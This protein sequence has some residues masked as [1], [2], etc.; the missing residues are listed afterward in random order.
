MLPSRLVA[1]LAFL[2]LFR[3]AASAEP[4]RLEDFS[5]NA[6]RT[7]LSAEANREGVRWVTGEALSNASAPDQ[8]LRL[9]PSFSLFRRSSSVGANPTAQGVSL[10]GIGPSG[11]SRTLVLLDGV[12]LNDPFGG[13]I[14]WT[15]L[16]TLALAGAE[17][18]HGGGSAAWGNAALSGT[19]ALTSSPLSSPRRELR[20]DAGSQDTR[21]ATL[22][23]GQRFGRTA[24]RVDA[25]HFTTEG[26]HPL[27]PADRGLIDRPLSSE[28]LLVQA[29]LEHE[30]DAVSAR[31]ALRHFA[32]ER[33]NGTVLQKN[34]SRLDSASLTLRGRL[35]ADVWQTALYRQRQTF[36]SFF[37]GIGAGR[38][39]E[40]PANDQFDV[41]S[42]AAGAGLT[43]AGER[44][45]TRFTTGLDY[46]QVRGETREDFLFAN[47]NFTRRRFAGGGQDFRGAFFSV[48]RDL[49]KNLEALL[50]VRADRWADRDGHR[51][52][53]DRN[54]GAATRTERYASRRGDE[55]HGTLALTWRPSGAWT[56]RGSAYTAFRLPTLNELYRPFRV[57]NVNTEANPAL[58]AESLR[59]VEA[60][61]AHQTERA[62]FAL[63][64]FVNELHDAVANVTLATSPTLVSRQRLNLSRL[65]VRGLE[66]QM[67]ITAFRDLDFEASFFRVDSRVAAA[68]VQPALV[69]R[70]VAQVPNLTLTT[71]AEWR[72]TRALRVSA[73]ARWS[74]AQFEDDENTLS[75]AS[76]GTLDVAAEH[77]LNPTLV[78]SLAVE[79]VLDR[80]VAAARSAGGP[81]SYASPRV[82]RA[83]VR[84]AF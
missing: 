30:F 35:G 12:P 48:E 1:C 31:L 13:W 41:P 34:S 47:G 84:L 25:R 63:T 43:Y 66:G 42:D 72:A 83:S 78:V 4:V 45:A 16:P 2:T 67:R 75:L 32:E 3:S 40:T 20:L 37:S 50:Q 53:I 17:I 70:R 7:G 74:S 11:A 51:R 9:D 73:Q 81:T 19:I 68:A 79:N 23:L 65:R 80:A 69:G 6:A 22:A 33:G 21:S 59:G 82:V 46:R 24:A 5:V 54:S 26:Y 10:R 64:G 71:G 52:E 29:Q 14:T 39:T 15:Q 49:A 57:G 62:S 44:A 61:V 8:A 58:A 76:G 38:A 36:R 27:E 56:V 60:G 77:R 28:N 55:Q 18:R